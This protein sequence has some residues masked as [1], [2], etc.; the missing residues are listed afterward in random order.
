MRTLS[1]RL[2]LAVVITAAAFFA[3]S[4]PAAEPSRTVVFAS[5]AGGY[6][7]Y[8]IPALTVTPKGTLLAFCEGRKTTRADHGDLDLVL[9]RSADGGQSWGPTQL[10]YEEGG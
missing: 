1:E 8:R 10:V 5:G 3:S 9:R 4:T 2:S 6:H 7:T